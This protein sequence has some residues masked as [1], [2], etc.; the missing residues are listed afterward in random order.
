MR[1]AQRE[2]RG[3]GEILSTISA[4]AITGLVGVG[5]GMGMAQIAPSD[6][7]TWAGLAVVPLWFLLEIVFEMAVGLFGSHSKLAR[8]AGTSTLLLGFYIAWFAARPI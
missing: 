8:I 3:V 1:T 7:F 6:K 2:S 5:T 4:S